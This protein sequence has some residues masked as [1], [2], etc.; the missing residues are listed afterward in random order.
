MMTRWIVPMDDE[1]TMLIELRHVSE[2]DEVTPA[3]WADRDTML[4]AQLPISDALEEQ[5]R[6]PGDYEAQVTQRPI[7]V[8]GMEHLGAS[9]RGITVYRRQIRVG[10]QAVREGRDPLGLSPGK[11]IPMATFSNDTV[12]DAPPAS[13]YEEDVKLMKEVGRGLIEEY[14]ADPPNLRHLK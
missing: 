8:H 11:D 7:A 3:W 6:Q 4:P 5:Q 14:I 1:N 2:E 9:D 13:S 10:I 12:V